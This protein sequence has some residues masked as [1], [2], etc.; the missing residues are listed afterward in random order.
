MKTI[1][2]S[3]A[4]M[5]ASTAW[6]G[7]PSTTPS[8]NPSNQLT[9]GADGVLAILTNNVTLY[10]QAILEP[11]PNNTQ[12]I[13]VQ[14]SES[15]HPEVM[16]AYHWYFAGDVTQSNGSI[17]TGCTVRAFWIRGTCLGLMLGLGAGTGQA[18]TQNFDTTVLGLVIGWGGNTADVQSQKY[19]FGLVWGH[20][21][22]VSTLADGEYPNQPLPAGQTQ[23]IYTTKDIVVHGFIFSY[24]WGGGG[25]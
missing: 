12:I 6:A 24:A 1:L 21:Y 3:L 25:S 17:K 23:I 5:L 7:A 20:R 19:N 4:L 2:A 15:F 22:G 16:V 11:G 18:S 13:R 9:G 14:K 10:P 8:D